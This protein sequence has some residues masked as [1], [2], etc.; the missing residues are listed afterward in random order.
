MLT[1]DQLREVDVMVFP[2]HPYSPHLSEG[3]DGDTAQGLVKRLT[4][5]DIE[6]LRGVIARPFTGAVGNIQSQEDIGALKAWLNL[7]S[8]G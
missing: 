1:A 6:K 8:I 5:A 4:G 3:V 2:S 7:C